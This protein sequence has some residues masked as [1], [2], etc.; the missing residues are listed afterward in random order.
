MPIKRLD[1]L[2][3]LGGGVKLDTRNT[4]LF[5]YG[6]KG[7]KWGVRRYQNKDG[8]LTNA[9]QK[10]YAKSV[11]KIANKKNNSEYTKVLKNDTR[12]ADAIKKTSKAANRY[13]ELEDK[14]DKDVQKAYAKAEKKAKAYI[15]K[16]W[17]GSY[18]SKQ[19][20]AQ[21]KRDN[22]Y[23]DKWLEGLTD[24]FYKDPPSAKQ[25]DKAW[26]EY[27][28]QLR[29]TVDSLVG[30]YGDRKVSTLNTTYNTVDQTTVRDIVKNTIRSTNF[31]NYYRRMRK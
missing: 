2:N 4:E 1:I 11:R 12:M 13:L 15:D 19:P 23:Y 27:D 28:K 26:D 18:P 5:H 25:A 10:R 6:V 16:N 9:G 7:M 17:D 21:K 8:S 30:K 14:A 31:E 22:R 3:R 24:E 29:S 20:G